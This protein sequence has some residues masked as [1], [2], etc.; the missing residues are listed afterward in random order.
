MDET[1]T[2]NPRAILDG[3][4]R[5]AT[6]HET[7][8]GDGIMISHMWDKSGG[9]A[10]VVVL[11]HGGAGSWRHWVHNIPVLMQRY[12]V[13]IP[14]LPGLGESDYPPNDTSAEAIAEIV[15]DGVSAIVGDE[16]GYDV[17]G[18]S[19]GGTMAGCIGNQRPKQVRSVTL[20]CSGGIDEPG[21]RG[22]QI[23]MEKVR[24]LEGQLRRETHRINL[25]RLM[26]ADPARID[27]LALEIQDWNTVRSRLKTP[28]ISRNGAINR[29]ISEMKCPLNGMWGERDAPMNPRGPIRAR[30]LK[31]V[32]PDADVR[33][34]P[35][36]GHWAAFEAPDFVN[37][38]LLEMLARTRPAGV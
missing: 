12:R 29:A 1:V 13:L 28:P 15:A 21:A 36:A 30:V 4:E 24:H 11:C 17:V 23:P 3:L 35:G 18:F 6:R 9:A 10:P 2:I 26:I 37:P 19:F 20:I 22:S 14:D 7:P 16:T 5:Q 33:I 31:E 32:R 25:G 8:C 38:V 34:V 27:D